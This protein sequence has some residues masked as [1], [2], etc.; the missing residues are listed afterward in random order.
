[1]PNFDPIWAGISLSHPRT[2]MTDKASTPP[3]LGA[4][5]QSTEELL[6]AQS[7]HE[8]DQLAQV[9]AELAALQAKSAELADQY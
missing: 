1:M 8:A 4:S 5:F 9:Q 2:G 6:A 3:N 7:L